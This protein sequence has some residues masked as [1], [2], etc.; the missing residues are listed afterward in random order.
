MRVA[1]DAS[2]RLIGGAL[3]VRITCV[4]AAYRFLALA[5]EDLLMQVDN[6][7]GMGA[8]APDRNDRDFERSLVDLAARIWQR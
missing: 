4:I 7:V 3:K 6:T 8:T 5:H 1:D 2:E